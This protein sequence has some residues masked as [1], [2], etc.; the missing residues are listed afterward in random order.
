M[1]EIK[2]KYKQ[3]NNIES[4]IVD[5]KEEIL[6][7][8]DFLKACI[9]KIYDEIIEKKNTFINK[10]F[11]PCDNFIDYLNKVFEDIE[12]KINNVMLPIISSIIKDCLD[13][14][15]SYCFDAGSKLINKIENFG[16]KL[17][18]N[19]ENKIN[20]HLI[21]YEQKVVNKAEEGFN[22]MKKF[23][24]KIKFNKMEILLKEFQN[25][26]G[27]IKDYEQNENE[28]E[29]ITELCD[30]IK[31]ELKIMICDCIKES[32]LFELFQMDYSSFI[33]NIGLN[34]DNI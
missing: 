7:N 13:K 31:K 19:T 24:K 22:N 18:D 4:N 17:I 33:K 14:V 27:D 2:E 26:C 1:D 8:I 3:L 9:Y 10:I 23:L 25:L 5:T 6:Y 30:A 34:K 12:Y 28:M 21:K 20:T 16:D 15:T 11:E 29:I 32:E